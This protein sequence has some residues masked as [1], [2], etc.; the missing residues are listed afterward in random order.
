MVGLRPVIALAAVALLGLSCTMAAAASPRQKTAALAAAAPPPAETEP[1]PQPR[2]YLFRGAMGPIFST[3]MD[4]LAE[5]LTKAGLTADTY[6]FTICRLVAS[7]AISTYRENPAPIVL[8]GHSMGG[9]C[10]IIFAEMMAKED[11]P[12][13]LI[14]TIDPAHA[15]G[16]VPLNVERFINIFFSDGVLGGGDVVAEP[17]YRGHY[18][19]FDL[20]EQ[21]RISH[22]NIEKASDIQA[23]LVDM[24]TQLTRVP[25][26]TVGEAVPLRYL[27]PADSRIELWDSG[28]RLPMK[29][30]A[31][32]EQVAA[33]YR[34]PLWSLAQANRQVGNTPLAK[35]Q[36]IVIPRHLEP[37]GPDDRGAPDGRQ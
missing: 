32:L 19:S 33:T 11:I 12:V 20:K 31:T 22:I 16:K 10:S 30:S 36:E 6:E 15:T 17:G 24:V 3:G 8:I 4:T 13:S 5:K 1:P 29:K 9:L 37:A 25:E 14:V 23:Q 28:I 34:L 7:H 35:G 18:A 26:Q 2:V 27:V 21:K